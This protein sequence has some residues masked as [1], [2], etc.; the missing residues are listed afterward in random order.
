MWYLSQQ[1][2][3]DL[4]RFDYSFRQIC[5]AFKWNKPAIISSHRVNFCGEIDP[6][7]RSKGLQ[8]LKALLKR[9]AKHYPDVEFMSSVELG[10][11]ISNNSK[12]N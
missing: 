9:V 12:G 6:E 2:I 10:K 1:M 11:I 7:N 5:T 4:I 3:E 8:A